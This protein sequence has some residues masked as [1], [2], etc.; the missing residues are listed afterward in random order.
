MR[1]LGSMVTVAL[2]IVFLECHST[3]IRKA[4]AETAVVPA[5][6]PLFLKQL[7]AVIQAARMQSCKHGF[8]AALFGT[9]MRYLPLLRTAEARDT[10]CSMY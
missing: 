9:T 5:N 3:A 7:A 1:S 8:A 6:R 10:N 2:D 4:M